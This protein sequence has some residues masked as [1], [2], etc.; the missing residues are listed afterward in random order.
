MSL[1]LSVKL[2]FI[3]PPLYFIFR[4]VYRT[5]TLR[6]LGVSA[7]CKPI[8]CAGSLLPWA[9]DRK[10]AVLSHKP[11]LFLDDYVTRRYHEEGRW[12]Y[13]NDSYGLDTSICAADPRLLQAVLATNFTDWGLGEVRQRAVGPLLGWNGVFTS[14]GPMWHNSRTL[15]RPQFQREQVSDLS[16]AEKHVGHLFKA[17]EEA[18]GDLLPLLLRFTLDVTTEFLCS[19]SVDSQTLLMKNGSPECEESVQRARMLEQAFADANKGAQLRLKAGRFHWW[20]NTR[21]FRDACATWA[22]Y[23]DHFVDAALRL[24]RQRTEDRHQGKGADKKDKYLFLHDMADNPA[25]ENRILMRDLVIQLLFAGE[26]TTASLLAFVLRCLAHHPG[27]WAQLR[28]EVFSAFG[29]ESAGKAEITFSSLKACTYLQNVIKETLRLYPP[30]P[31]NAREALQ[32]TVL[33]V[34]GGKYG[35]DPCVVRK[36]T[37]VKYSP[38]VMHRR[39]D[40]WGSDAKEWKPDRWVDKKVGWEYLPFNGGPRICIGQQFAL[41]EAAY[42]IVRIAQHFEQVSCTEPELEISTKLSTA[43][44]PR[45]G[46]PLRFIRSCE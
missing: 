16:A 9:L 5:Y 4:S 27:A 23:G 12:V 21:K 42:A 25:P 6:R 36:G 15:L 39:E 46:V 14:D 17:M 38:Y 19:D 35:N 28:D 41:T 2:L 44:F 10:F 34:G 18:E 32:D 33:P 37:V 43:L 7:G 24:K 13:T 30:I 45:K 20:T 22:N 29:T 31:M 11:E 3:L 1:P 40:I 26:D 8:H